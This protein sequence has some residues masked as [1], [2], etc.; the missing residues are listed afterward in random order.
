MSK[1]TSNKFSPLAHVADGPRP[2]ERMAKRFWMLFRR[3]SRSRFMTSR[4]DCI[5]LQHLVAICW[6]ERCSAN[7]L[8]DSGPAFRASRLDAPQQK[9]PKGGLPHG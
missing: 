4:V 6:V 3:C 7:S 8:G 1:H 9:T 2:A 5:A